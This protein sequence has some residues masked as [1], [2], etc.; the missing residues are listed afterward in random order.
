MKV[1]IAD[2]EITASS[3]IADWMVANGWPQPGIAATSDEAIEW[4]NKNEGIDVLVADVALSPLD[5]PSLRESLLPHFPALKVVFLAGFDVSAHAGRMA[6]CG[7]LAKP[8]TG[9]AV[10]SAI[11]ALY[12]QTE[13]QPTPVVAPV[14]TPKVAAPQVSAA[15]R[16]A[17][18]KVAAPQV[19]A[20]P[21][22]AAPQVSAT[23]K[24]AAPQVS[25]T[26]KVAAP[27]VS[28]TPNAGVRHTEGGCPASVRHS[29]GGCSAGVR[30]TEGGC[31]ASVRRSEGCCSAGVRCTEGGWS[32]REAPAK[33]QGTG[34][35][36]GGAQFW[37]SRDAA[38]RAGWDKGWRLRD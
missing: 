20:A 35:H 16:A 22:V 12:E 33:D 6:G 1:L 15:P 19:S 4:I 24:V 21:K 13:P 3:A 11:R 29:E 34:C 30:H 2:S 18:P 36:F 38:R 32:R 7:L 23:P 37:G 25:A 31:S 14:A 28:A 27:Q 26:P 9:E 5:G 17:A 10:D 8:A